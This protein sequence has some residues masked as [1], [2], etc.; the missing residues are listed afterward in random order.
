MLPSS[1]FA[2]I[3]AVFVPQA[4]AFFAFGASR[5]V[6]PGGIFVIGHGVTNYQSQVLGK[7]QETMFQGA[8]V[9]HQRVINPAM[10]GDKL[11]HDSA[12]RT[13]KFILSAL[14]GQGKLPQ[15]PGFVLRVQQGETG[16]N[17]QSC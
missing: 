8:A 6:F 4:Y 11:V 9:K 3:S 17:F 2:A 1:P 13:H 7:T 15:V 16:G 10:A 5:V 12:A 14:T